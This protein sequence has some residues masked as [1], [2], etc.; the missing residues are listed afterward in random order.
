MLTEL[1]RDHRGTTTFY[2]LHVTLR[3]VPTPA[4]HPPAVNRV[5]RR[6]HGQVVLT[7]R[8]TRYAPGTNRAAEFYAGKDD[9]PDTRR[10]V[11]SELAHASPSIRLGQLV[12]ERGASVD[13]DVHAL[14]D[15]AGSVLALSSCSASN[16]RDSPFVLDVSGAEGAQRRLLQAASTLMRRWVVALATSAGGRLHVFSNG[17]HY[18]AYSWCVV[19][20]LAGIRAVRPGIRLTADPTRASDVGARPAVPTDREQPGPGAV[21]TSHR[22]S[23]QIGRRGSIRCSRGHQIG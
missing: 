17:K 1:A 11:R 7:P 2:Y 8:R 6:A 18:L 13:H 14:P 15:A 19:R 16:Q 21:R 20:Q 5:R 22:P 4:R 3:R 9:G 12:T 23:R 10:G